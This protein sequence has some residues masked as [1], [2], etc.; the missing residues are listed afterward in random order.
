MTGFEKISESALRCF[1]RLMLGEEGAEDYEI[2]DSERRII[3]K[4]SDESS[5]NRE[6]DI[7][8]SIDYSK[9]Y[10]K[11]LNAVRKSKR[12]RRSKLFLR[13]AAGIAAAAVIAVA[14]VIGGVFRYSGGVTIINKY[15]VGDSKRVLL[16]TPDGETYSTSGDIK[17]EGQKVIAAKRD[18]LSKNETEPRV[19]KINELIT[20][21]GV[22]QK[23]T[24]PDGSVVW[25]NA[26]SSLKFPSEFEDS[27][28]VVALSGEAFFDVTKSAKRFIVKIANADVR[29][30][31]TTFN[32]SSYSNASVSNVSL[33]TGSVGLRSERGSLMLSP[34]FYA[35][36]NNINLTISEPK[37]NFS[38]SPDWMRGRMEFFS[39]P[40]NKV[41]EVIGRWYNI[42]Y[43][44]MNG[45]EDL[46]VTITISDKTSLEELIELFKMTQNISVL[47]NDKKLIIA[48]NR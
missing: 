8:N 2:S 26:G 17:V 10:S 42:D 29:V 1:K 28:R 14:L 43:E 20:P 6:L 36:L 38:D 12:E 48:K 13:A 19:S 45:A 25:L 5:L 41:F 4:Y 31:G 3:E 35:E 21:E 34:G 7:F 46:E 27:A 37:E 18:L 22:R 40:L 32:I 9:A 33:Y 24:L 47:R 16:I 39:Q 23:I 11:F 30:Y 44:L 15:A